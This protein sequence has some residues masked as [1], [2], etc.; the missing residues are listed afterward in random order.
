MSKYISPGETT[1]TYQ[2]FILE[3]LNRISSLAGGE[4]S[5]YN[6]Q[7]HESCIN[8]LWCAIPEGYKE[9]YLDDWDKIMVEFNSLQQGLSDYERAERNV[10][11]VCH[12]RQLLTECL[13]DMKLLFAP[14]GSFHK[15]V[16][17]K[18]E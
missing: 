8:D 5:S 1:W 6:P 15:N 3:A 13:N 2:Q 16:F 11:R 18:G 7:A 12:K 9:D 17:S 4:G 10:S 14:V